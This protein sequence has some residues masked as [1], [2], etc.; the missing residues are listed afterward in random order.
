MM[1]INP[2]ISDF[3]GSSTSKIPDTIEKKLNTIIRVPNNDTLILGG[4]ITDSRTFKSSGVP[5]L[6]EIPILKYVFG[7]KEKLTQRKE[8][9][10]VIT[11]HIVDF[12]KK[13]KLKDLNY[14]IPSLEEFK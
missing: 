9:V 14:K 12:N 5:V 7:Y 3:D 2:S 11:P 8:L 6:K 13:I 10:F 4:L 1:R